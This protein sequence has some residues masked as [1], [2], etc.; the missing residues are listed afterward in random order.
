MSNVP[1]L[2]K[3]HREIGGFFVYQHT[4]DDVHQRRS[5]A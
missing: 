5:P 4:V 1:M 3:S 2:R